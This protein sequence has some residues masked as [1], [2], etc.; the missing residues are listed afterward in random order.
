MFS[1]SKPARFFRLACAATFF[2]FAAVVFGAYVRQADTALGCPDGPACAAKPVAPI[3]AMAALGDHKNPQ[4][5]WQDMVERYI[6]G[7]LGLMMIRLAVLGWQLRHRPGQQVVIPLAV[8][9][10]V[11]GLTAVSVF[12]MD[13]QTKPLVLTIK[14]LGGLLIVALL[15]W[16]VLRQQRIFRSVTPTPMTRQLRWRA[17]FALVIALLAIVS[18]SWST[19]NYAGLACPDFPM[20][21]GQY[22]PDADFAGGLLRWQ[23]EGLAFDRTELDL[24]AATAIQLTHRA[25]AL[26][27]LLYLG[28]FALRL[29]RVGIQENLCR[30]GLLLLVMLSFAVA[31]GI[32]SAVGGLE[33]SVGVAHTATAALLFLTL[34]TIYHV[35]RA[36]S[37]S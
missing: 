37:R 13:L 5:P 31:F 36:P 34:V 24:A 18:G 28:W 10:L 7:A 27:A 32:M 12:T 25:G 21:Q 22:W 20:C 26:M 3:V 8:L 11:F 6:A 2:A 23:A 35:L 19:T 15:W 9:V 1:K 17:L 30:Y 16:V 14:F 33:L 29:L 4:R